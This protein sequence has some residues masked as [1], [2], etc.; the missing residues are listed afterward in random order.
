MDLYLIIRLDHPSPTHNLTHKSEEPTLFLFFSFSSSMDGHV[1]HTNTSL[2]EVSFTS[3]TDCLQSSLVMDYNSLEK[4]FKFPPYS[5]PFQPIS[6]SNMGQIVNN[7]Y[8]NLN[9]NSP[10]VSSSS[11]EAETKENPDD[12]SGQMEGNER[13]KLGV[14][15]S[16]KQL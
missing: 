4:V 11:N 13:D 7:P 1:E 3:L 5:S 6:P 15:E 14:G 8:I 16:S 9:S 12:K 2:E 10:V